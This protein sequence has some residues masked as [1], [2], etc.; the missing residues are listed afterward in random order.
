[1]RVMVV[2]SGVHSPYVLGPGEQL[3]PVGGPT[4]LGLESL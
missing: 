3:P 2:L 4:D 1:V